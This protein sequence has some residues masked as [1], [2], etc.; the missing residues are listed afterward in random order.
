MFSRTELVEIISGK[1]SGV[2]AILVRQVLWLLT[3]AYRFAIWMRNRRFEAAIARQDSAVI[4]RA[5]IPV[6]SVG[7]LTTGGTG[8]TPLVIWIARYLR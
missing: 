4:K 8:K 6:I 2:L 3:P 1:R 5:G 7:N